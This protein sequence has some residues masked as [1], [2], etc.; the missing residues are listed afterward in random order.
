MR[1]KRGLGPLFYEVE[2]SFGEPGASLTE[3][4][5][6]ELRKAKFSNCGNTLKQFQ[7]SESGNTSRGTGNDSWYGK[8]EIDARK[9]MGYP[10]PIT[11]CFYNLLISG[12]QFND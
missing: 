5:V 12:V 1:S 7:P 11:E 9:E 8:I 10:Q 4:S 2:K 3:L 6:S